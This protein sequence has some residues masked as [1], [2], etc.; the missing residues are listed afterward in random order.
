MTKVA[1]KTV[2]RLIIYRKILTR[3][4]YEGVDNIYSQNLAKLASCS[5]EQVRNDLMTIGYHGT[6]AK[7]YSIHDLE[8]HLGVFLDNPSGQRIA[9]VGVGKLGKSVIEYCYWNFQNLTLI[10]GFD[11]DQKKIG[12]EIAGCMIYPVEKIPVLIPKERINVGIISCP[13]DHAQK[14]TDMLVAAGIK[15]ILNYTPARL[16]T[17]SEIMVE[18]LDMLIPLETVAFFARNQA[19]FKNS[20]K[21]SQE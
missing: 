10:L 5:P 9:I 11:T 7:G 4:I 18:D 14:M 6:P 2:Q 16:H 3:L 20:Q 1:T 12:K 15:G 13:P 17:P 21:E 19:V 8:Y